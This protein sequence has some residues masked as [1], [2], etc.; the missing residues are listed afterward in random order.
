MN[1]LEKIILPT[2]L[3]LDCEE[4][5]NTAIKLS[6]LCN[7]EILILHVL[8][9]ENLVDPVLHRVKKNAEKQLNIIKATFEKESISVQDPL[10]LYG[11]PA[12][13]IIKTATKKGV[14][15]ILTGS[16]SYLK[17]EKF[18]RGST[19]EK[20][21]RSADIPVWVVKLDT[22]SSL[23]NILCPIDF[24]TP[25]RGALK[26]ALLLSTFFNAQVTILGVY[27]TYTHLSNRFEVDVE[28]E[29]TQRLEHFKTKMNTFL[30]AFD[31]TSIKHKIL[32]KSGVP[33]QQILQTI[34]EANHDLLIMGTHG[35]SGIRK[36]IMGSVTEKVTREVPCSFITTKNEDIIQLKYDDEILEIETHFN[37]GNELFEKKR[38]DEALGH[39]TI[40]LQI[41]KLHIPS[42]IKLAEIFKHL[43]DPKKAKEYSDLSKNL[44]IRLWGDSSKAYMTK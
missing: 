20:L 3:H 9:F 35:R 34:K 41:N 10:I 28:E 30:A 44:L 39:Y 7:S 38:F 5:I 4:Q 31:L 37:K 26:N 25:S 2:D 8:P 1:L 23:K 12:D 27:E 17:N 32:I 36:F 24:S 11:K 29:N 40:C 18:K 6:K 33:D 13:N 42:I 43:K 14:D 15:L 21:M 22:I 16:G 19:A